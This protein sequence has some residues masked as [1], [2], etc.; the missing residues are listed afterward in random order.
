MRSSR[1][2]VTGVLVFTL[3]VG[4]TGICL[5][6]VCMVVWTMTCTRCFYH[7]NCLGYR[8]R[9][10]HRTHKVVWTIKKS[11]EVVWTCRLKCINFSADY[12]LCYM[13]FGLASDRLC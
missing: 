4:L 9:L 3:E 12:K 2:V 10:D 6:K 7:L 13:S 1:P 8:G 11:T 5:N